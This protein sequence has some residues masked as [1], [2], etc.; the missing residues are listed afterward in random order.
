LVGE[1]NLQEAYNQLLTKLK[2]VEIEKGS[3]VV[4]LHEMDVVNDSLKHE[5]SMLIDIKSLED[6]CNFFDDNFDCILGS[7]NMFE[8]KCELHSV[9]IAFALKTTLVKKAK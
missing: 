3:L 4:K 1:T 2:N 8:N 7:K 9:K 6:V 5:N